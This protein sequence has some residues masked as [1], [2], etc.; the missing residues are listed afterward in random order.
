MSKYKIWLIPIFVVVLTLVGL[1]YFRGKLPEEPAATKVETTVEVVPTPT[2]PKGFVKAAEPNPQE[3]VEKDT[4]AIVAALNSGDISGCAEITWNEELKKRC[5]DDLNYP[6]ALKSGDPSQCKKIHNKELKDQCYNKVYMSNAVDQKDSGLCNK[7]T[8]EALKEM[9]LDQVLMIVS[10]NA[11][12][13]SD[14]AA[15]N[16]EQLRKQ[17]EDSYYLKSSAKELNEAGCNNISDPLMAE[18]CKSTVSKN[19]NV[20]EQSKKAEENANVVKSSQEILG[21][22][23]NLT[24]NKVLV[25]KDAVYPQLAYDK[26]DLS[27]CE[28]ISDKNKIEECKEEQSER[29]NTYYLRQAIAK[30]DKSLCGQI[31][32]DDLKEVCQNS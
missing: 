16:S 11:N 27:Y 30:H 10:R 8:D 2:K 22:C 21:M 18:R 32:D 19:I 14:C 23:S 28:N 17:C 4:D 6:A 13:I 9:C 29:I 25:C 5:E 1:V 3:K 7:I 12:S 26:K 31:L 20:M 24:G 15:I